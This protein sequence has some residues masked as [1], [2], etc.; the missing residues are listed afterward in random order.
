MVLEEA[1]DGLALDAQA[2]HA[3]R[4]VDLVDCIGRNEPATP[5]EKAGTHRKRVRN[6][7][8]RAVHRALDLSDQPAAAIGHDVPG[9]AAEVDGERTTHVDDA[10]P[11]LKRKSPFAGKHCVK[12]VPDAAKRVP[13]VCD[14][15]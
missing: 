11:R 3:A 5:R 1:A 12:P 2:D 7:G 14:Y 10:I 4:A 6:V 9:G 8:R 13:D 15:T